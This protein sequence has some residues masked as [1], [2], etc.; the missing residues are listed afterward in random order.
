MFRSILI[1]VDR[2]TGADAALA[3]ARRVAEVT[4]GLL[5]LLTVTSDGSSA[6]W[7]SASGFVEGLAERLR[8]TGLRA[9]AAIRSGEPANEIIAYARS[10]GV[11]LIVIATRAVANRSILA[12][13]STARR[14]V[15]EGPCPVLLLGPDTVEPRQLRTLLVPVDGSPGGALAVAAAAALAH[16]S[17][18]RLV[19]LQVVVPVLTHVVANPP[20]MT[21]G[22]YV[23]ADWEE[24]ARTTALMYVGS[25]A[26]RLTAAGY[27][28]EARVATGNVTDEIVRCADDVD[29]DLVV[30]STHSA[31]WPGRAYVGSVADRVLRC[32]RRPV[33][34]VRR[35]PPPGEATP[36]RGLDLAHA[37]G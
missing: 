26:Q 35:E 19:V 15:A 34:V 3:T 23:D 9:Y 4:G 28:C 37:G 29:A 32:G 31:D 14:I 6:T 22:G 2:G 13:T 10:R 12:L 30:M 17:G 25:V 1:P 36:D 8:G 20:A 21:T 5:H 33:L 11:D 27:C 24:L 18:G 7:T 16:A